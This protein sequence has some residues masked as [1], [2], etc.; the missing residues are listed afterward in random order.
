MALIMIVH[1]IGTIIHLSL[2]VTAAATIAIVHVVKAARYPSETATTSVD[3]DD[4]GNKPARL[5]SPVYRRLTHQEV[6][7]SVRFCRSPHLKE[8]AQSW[9]E[10]GKKDRCRC[11]ST[12][13]RRLHAVGILMHSPWLPVFHALAQAI[14]SISTSN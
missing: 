5:V 10:D 6:R 2:V 7:G 13:S 12:L 4:D 9:E 8:S 1:I 11:P 3:D 14:L